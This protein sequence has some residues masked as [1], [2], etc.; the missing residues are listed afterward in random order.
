M[1]VAMTYN[2]SRRSMVDSMFLQADL[3]SPLQQTY[4]FISI[5][6]GGFLGHWT[7]ESEMDVGYVRLIVP[8]YRVQTH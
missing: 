7:Y 3:V 4:L 8:Q 6:L 5:I 2:V 1:L